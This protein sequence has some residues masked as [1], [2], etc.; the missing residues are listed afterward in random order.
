MNDENKNDIVCKNEITTKQPASINTKEESPFLSSISTE[1]KGTFNETIKQKL[2]ATN[3]T[4]E[5]DGQ[6]NKNV[7]FSADCNLYRFV[8]GKT[9]LE[10]RGVG[11]IFIVKVEESGLYKLVMNRDKINR[12]GCNH[13][14][15][16]LVELQPHSKINDLWIWHTFTDTCD[17]DAKLDAKQTFA[18]RIKVIE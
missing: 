16:P 8:V 17:K 1:K 2:Q 11:K 18:V 3:S 12:L 4:A 14:I 5:I 9:T 15:S 6:N 7:I 10:A 13:Y